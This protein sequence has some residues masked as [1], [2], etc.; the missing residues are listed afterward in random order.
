MA[1]TQDSNDR[2]YSDAEKLALA[3]GSRLILPAWIVEIDRAAINPISTAPNSIGV[4]ASGSLS[5]GGAGADVSR[6]SL[7]SHALG[8]DVGPGAPNGVEAPEFINTGK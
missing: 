4:G 5:T 8:V 6:M 2:N 1:T 3:R 7:S